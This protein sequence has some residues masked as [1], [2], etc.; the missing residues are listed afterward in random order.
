MS[1]AM[2][3]MMDGSRFFQRSLLLHDDYGAVNDMLDLFL[4][5][6]FQITKSEKIDTSLRLLSERPFD[7]IVTELDLAGGQSGA[8]LILKAKEMQ[9]LIRPFITTAR[10]QVGKDLAGI[11]DDVTV[12]R[13]PFDVKLM[14]AQ[15]KDSISSR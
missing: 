12:F 14:H 7:G 10:V 13:K 3:S 15:I 1:Q 11:K 2:S 9:P 6:D 5:R 8:D 4:S